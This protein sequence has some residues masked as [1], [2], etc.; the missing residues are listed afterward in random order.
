M[1]ECVKKLKKCNGLSW[2]LS[3]PSLYDVF[4]HFV[5]WSSYSDYE[6][7][8]EMNVVSSID[9]TFLFEPVSPRIN[10]FIHGFLKAHL[11]YQQFN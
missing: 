1:L 6:K 10:S 5:E 2:L 8:E 7:Y 11:L 4:M 3:Q 9:N